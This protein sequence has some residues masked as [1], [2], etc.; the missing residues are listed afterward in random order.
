MKIDLNMSD[1]L[2]LG[3]TLGIG[4]SVTQRIRR[5]TMRQTNKYMRGGTAIII[6]AGLGLSSTAFSTDTSEPLSELYR[7]LPRH[8]PDVVLQFLLSVRS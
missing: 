8:K 2:T 3:L 6:A 5:L 7:L 4:H 1:P